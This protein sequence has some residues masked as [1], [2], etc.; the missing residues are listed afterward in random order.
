MLLVWNIDNLEYHYCNYVSGDN[1][2]PHNS[3][4]I[5]IS[6]YEGSKKNHKL[7]YMT[8]AILFIIFS[9]AVLFNPLCP[10]CHKKLRRHRSLPFCL[11]RHRRHHLF[12]VDYLFVSSLFIFVFHMV[13]IVVHEWF[14]YYVMTFYVTVIILLNIVSLI[15]LNP[16]CPFRRHFLSVHSFRLVLSPSSY[17]PPILIANG[18][19][20]F[21]SSSVKGRDF[22]RPRFCKVVRDNRLLW[23]VNFIPEE[24]RGSLFYL[25]KVCRYIRLTL[26]HSDTD[27]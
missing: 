6:S 15:L 12:S 27:S 18:G 10:S 9:F 8:S 13:I 5:R 25:G 23:P 16:L 24:E 1:P 7:L 3:D 4:S 22:C 20:I 14:C 17:H 26:H 19:S 2:F 21:F 11:F